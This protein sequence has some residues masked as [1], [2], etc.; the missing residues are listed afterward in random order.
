MKPKHVLGFT[1]S[2]FIILAIIMFVFPKNGI[3][4]GENFTL[5]FPNFAE[6]FLINNNI[7]KDITGVLKHQF[8]MDSLANILESDTSVADISALIG[9]IH[10]IEFPSRDK[11]IIYPIFEKLLNIKK[12]GELIRIMHYGD[13]Q[14]EGD[15]ITSFLRSKL[16]SKFGGSG[17]GIVPALQPYDFSF[18]INQT[19]SSNWLRYTSFGS[20]NKKI[21][22]KKYGALA[23]FSRFAPL[24]N[25]SVFSDTVMYESWVSFGKSALSYSN[26]KSFKK[27]R[28]FYGNAQRP[29][30]IGIYKNDVLIKSDSLKT[31]NDLYTFS[32]QQPELLDKLTIRFQGQDSPDIYGISI[33]DL[34]GVGVDNIALRG[35]SG[36]FFTA[37]DRSLLKKMY[38]QLNVEMFILQFGGNVM[39]YIKNEKECLDYGNWFYSQIALLKTLRPDAVVLVIGPSDMSTKEKD[40]YITYPLL[41]KVNSALRDA[42][43]R[44]GAGFWDMFNAMGGNNSMPGWVNANPPLA[45]K[46]YVHFSPKGANIIASM[47]YNAFLIEFEDYLKLQKKLK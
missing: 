24:R 12:S 16:Q 4:V 47:F 25:D 34:S 37:M 23:S 1:L 5:H 15:R 30:Y 13:S 11:T 32:F 36:T 28:I 42:S 38:D 6:I 20:I 33:E 3:K 2:V 35:S 22:H 45:A 9:S 31:G 40:K 19:S 43:H 29:V 14:I 46:D 21:K 10:R 39:P 7:S 8:D 17:V 44:A 26:T 18:S 41:N 27:G